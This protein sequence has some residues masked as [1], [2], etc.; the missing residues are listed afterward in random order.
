M[1]IQN[2]KDILWKRLK[3]NKACDINKLTVEHIRFCGDE[4]LHLILLLINN[5]LTNISVLSSP[6][7][8][9]AMA[10][11]I[12][13]QKNKSLFE[14]SSHRMVRVVPL[15]SRI[16]DEFLRP[17][18]VK[19]YKPIQNIN[20]YGFTGGVSYLMAALQRHE[21]EMFCVDEKKTFFSVS[22]DG[23]SAFEVVNRQIQLRELYMAGEIGEYW[24]ASEHEYSNTLTK[25][26]M[27][28]KLSQQIH[29]TLG[30][31]QGQVKSSYHYKVYAG[32]ALDTI[33]MAD[34]GVW[35]G[36]FNSGVSACAD[37]IL[38]ISDDPGKLQG[39]LDIASFYGKMYHVKYGAA[40]TKVTIT[41]SAIDMKYY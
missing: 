11:V 40:K 23:A 13:K 27:N 15:F 2:L 4:T 35:I 6:Q 7:L 12:Y 31:R 3:P 25:I 38:G 21:T 17:V 10:T 8:N 34:L 39:I 37:D 19:I 29:E 36:P 18:F 32:P 16:I 20:Q 33:D 24:Q 14:H 9:T 22:L 30:V 41:G 5:I 28:G 1:N 26:K